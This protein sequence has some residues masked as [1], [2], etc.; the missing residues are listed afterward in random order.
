MSNH[1]CNTPA[2]GHLGEHWTCPDCGAG[3]RSVERDTAMLG[4]YMVW[5]RTSWPLLYA[6]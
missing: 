5:E 4:V 6:D 2:T 3:W 1:P